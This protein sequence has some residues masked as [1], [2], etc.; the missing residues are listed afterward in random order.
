MTAMGFDIALLE[1][2]TEGLAGEYLGNQ[3]VN[4]QLPRKLT[5]SLPF[6]CLFLTDVCLQV[7]HL[8]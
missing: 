5:S 1:G 7:L 8:F 4:N 2:N 3:G 6:A